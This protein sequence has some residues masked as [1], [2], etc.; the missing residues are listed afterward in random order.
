[1]TRPAPVPLS[2]DQ[3]GRRRLGVF[4]ASELT[5]AGV[6]KAEIA[7]AVRNGSWV[8]L[9]PGILVTAADLAEVT[10]SAV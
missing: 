1:M 7:N 10:R 9:R 8:R 6:T 2:V 3:P 4:T 5:A